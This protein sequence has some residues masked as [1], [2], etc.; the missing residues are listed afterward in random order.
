MQLGLQYNGNGQSGVRPRIPADIEFLVPVHHGELTLPQIREIVQN[1]P[2]PLQWGCFGLGS[3]KAATIFTFL[4]KCG[5]CACVD[6]MIVGVTLMEFHLMYAALVAAMP[7]RA[8]ASR[9]MTTS[10]PDNSY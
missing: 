3:C 6:A 7:S 10:P 2:D 9:H 8:T 5:S 4:C 1:T